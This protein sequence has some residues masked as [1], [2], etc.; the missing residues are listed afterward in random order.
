MAKARPHRSP[1]IARRARVPRTNSSTIAAAT[2][3]ENVYASSPGVELPKPSTSS[4]TPVTSAADAGTTNVRPSARSE[5]RR[6]A[7]S[8]PI[9][10][11]SR[12]GSPKLCRK[13]L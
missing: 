4:A 3:A 9:P 8:G 1:A 5:A 10:I 6:H 7:T 12:S 13:K 11:S 2:N